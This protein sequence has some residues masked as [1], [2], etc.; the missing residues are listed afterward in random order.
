VVVLHHFYSPIWNRSTLDLD[1]RTKPAGRESVWPVPDHHPT[2]YCGEQFHLVFVTTASFLR[3]FCGRLAVLLFC[4]RR[5]WNDMIARMRPSVAGRDVIERP[6]CRPAAIEARP[7]FE[8]PYRPAQ[9]DGRGHRRE[10]FACRRG[11]YGI[12]TVMPRDFVHA[13]TAIT[14]QMARTCTTRKSLL[15]LGSAVRPG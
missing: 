12:R 13:K 14:Q 4:Q 11:K 9:D 3:P 15:M 8:L 5:S 7:R 6:E 1:G 2:V 10:S